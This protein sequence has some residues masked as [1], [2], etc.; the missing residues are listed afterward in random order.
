VEE[1]RY[2]NRQVKVP[3]GEWLPVVEA[4][5]GVMLI[6]SDGQVEGLNRV[7]DG[8]TFAEITIPGPIAPQP[9]ERDRVER[10]FLEW[11]AVEMGRRF[12]AKKDRL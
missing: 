10:E 8:I 12:E 1:W 9:A 4:N 7:D 11:R 2:E 5:F 3:L 6:V